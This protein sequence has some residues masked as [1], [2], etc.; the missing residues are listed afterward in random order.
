MPSSRIVRPSVATLVLSL[1]FAAPETT[2][3]NVTYRPGLMQ[4]KI[5]SGSPNGFATAASGIPNLASNLLAIARSDDKVSVERASGVLMDASYPAEN[6]V[7]GNSFSWPDTY[8]VFAYEGEIHV[9]AGTTYRFY[10]QFDDG[11]ALVVDGVTAV[12]QGASSGY[13]NA[14]AVRNPYAAASTGWVP[15]NAWI[16]DWTGGKAPHTSLYALEWNA[17]NVDSDFG[18]SAKWSQFRD[19]GS[20]TFLRTDTGETFTTIHSAEVSGNNL[21]LNVSFANVPASSTLVAYFGN[22]DGGTSSAGWDS[23]VPLGTISSGNTVETPLTVTGAG[24]AGYLRLCLSNPTKTSGDDFA[25]VFEE[26]TDPVNRDPAPAISLSLSSISYTNAVY[27]ARISSFGFG[28]SSCDLVFE[29]SGNDSFDSVAVAVSSSGVTSA[30]A[31]FPVSGLLTNTVY[32]ARVTGTNNKQNTGVSSIVSGTTLTP[33]N[34]ECQVE[35]VVSGLT[36][37]SVTGKA[38][39][40]GV[41]A[42]SATMRL[43]ASADAGFATLAG[44]AER[45]VALGES[46]TLAISGLAPDTEYRLRLRIVNDWGLETSTNLLATS[47]L[48]APIVASGIRRTFASDISTVDVFFDITAVFDGATGTATLY[49]DENDEPVTN[50]GV[51]AVS[52]PGTLTWAAIPFGG[53]AYHAKVVLVS[54]AN[55]VTYT[56]TWSAVVDHSFKRFRPEK[57]DMDPDF[58]IVEV[59]EGETSTISRPGNVFDG[60]LSTG[61]RAVAGYSIVG[62]LAEMLEVPEDQEVYVT[63]IDVTHDGNSNYS[64]YTSEDGS[65]WTLVEGVTNVAHTGTASYT[66]STVA[67]FVKCTFESSSGYLTSLYEIE[68]WGFVKEKPKVVSRRAIATWHKPD[69]SAMEA[70]GQGGWNS[71]CGRLFDGNLENYQMWPKAY[72]G[73]YV[74]VDFTKNAGISGYLTEYFVTELKVAQIGTKKYTL[75]YSIDGSTWI[76]VPGAVSVSGDGTESF[77]VSKTVKKVRYYWVDAKYNDYDDSY[78]AEFQVWGINPNDAPCDHPNYSDWEIGAVPATCTELARDQRK[79]LVCGAKFTKVSDGSTPLGHDYVTTLDR[80]GHFSQR[81]DY[82]DHRRYGMGTISCSRCAFRLDF[83]SALDLVT[84]RVGGVR[85]CGEKT[86]GIVRFT[87]LSASSENHPE[88]GPSKKKIIDE[89]WDVS[90][91]YPYWATASTNAQYADFEFG[92]TIDLTEVEIS[93]YNHGYRFDFRR[94]D[95]EGIETELCSISIVREEATEAHL[96]TIEVD[97]PGTGRTK[98]IPVQKMATADYQRIRVPFFETPVKHLRVR[99]VDDEPIDLWGCQSIR[100]IEIHPWGTVLG[101]SDFQSPKTTLMILR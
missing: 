99:I 91:Q 39:A 10:G 87:D 24:T 31:V 72:A 80:P 58:A 68:A 61:V 71:D 4:A 8:G 47:T 51:K 7:T 6:P 3:A 18:N 9:T 56:Q 23:S 37:L 29:I 28:A 86:E 98:E 49:C 15:F 12:N 42:T 48:D 81:K 11:E 20:M 97:V 82:L 67:N 14:P 73:C 57:F 88:Y 85:I 92:T 19:D 46:E 25:S 34:P 2:R 76:D 96:E 41:G 90:Q 65:T 32:Y 63:R 79:C 55:D 101:A 40:F 95:D 62:K 70:N 21:V 60:D 89:V 36:T 1:L 26:W 64:L 78:L 84:N 35:S 5:L 17:D 75:K 93:T 27:E 83:P 66:V 13:N 77:A 38:T 100:V 94:I 69:G 44:F 50:R 74:E 33:G 22:G 43:E 59:P 30:S 16:W 52:A 54:E 45:S 53:N